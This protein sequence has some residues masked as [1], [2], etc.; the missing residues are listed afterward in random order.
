MHNGGMTPENFEFRTVR[1][2]PASA[3]RRRR[4]ARRRAEELA[5]IQSDGWEII[6]TEPE[7]IFRR[8]DKI[9]VRRPADPP[10]V[11]GPVTRAES[12]PMSR[13]WVIMVGAVIGVL[14]LVVVLDAVL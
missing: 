8:G 12:P 5:A 7:R 13:S 9:T 2:T 11:P 4:H 14:L 10:P 1:V 3:T 6:D